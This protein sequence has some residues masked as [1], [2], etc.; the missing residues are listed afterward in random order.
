[1]QRNLLSH[2]D[3]STQHHLRLAMRRIMEQQAVIVA[4]NKRLIALETQIQN[5]STKVTVVEG[6]TAASVA[7]VALATRNLSERFDEEI[8]SIEKKHKSEILALH[9][10][11][12]QT[13][14]QVGGIDQRVTRLSVANTASAAPSK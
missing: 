10:A 7:A 8:K 12:T 4:V 1:M 13:N 9:K 2:L 14:T 3:D 5:N 6:T 11:L